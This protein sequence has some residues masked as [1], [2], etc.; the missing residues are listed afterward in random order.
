MI[1]SPLSELIQWLRA[2]GEPS[3]M[4]LL[5]LC[6]DAALSVSDLAHALRQSEPRVSRHLKILCESGLLERL[7]QGQWV[8][9]RLSPAPE[10]SSFVRGLLA[11]LDRRDPLLLR[12]AASAR[13]AAAADEGAR[14]AGGESRLGRALAGFVAAAAPAQRFD[15]LLLVGV[16]HPE[17]LEWAAGAS[18]HCT[19]LAPSRR[20][21]QSARA[22]AERRALACRVLHVR[23]GAENSST[24]LESVGP[25]FDALVLD[26]PPMSGERL[27]G[28]LESARALIGP[29]GVLWLFEPY[30]ALEGSRE[31]VVEHPLAR[32]RRLLAA[33][34]LRCEK[35]SPIEA[36][37]AHVLA[38]VARPVAAGPGLAAGA[39][40]AGR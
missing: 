16:T 31:R 15:S 12:D 8:H 22:F 11:Q 9:Y 7:R 1:Q 33:A 2:S 30:D 5:A 26:H 40:G 19:A 21:A 14:G 35:L 25:H 34:G 17:L 38:A 37:G 29:A 39:E 27:V 28:L 20:A 32:L 13:A 18:R 10:A 24:G 36:D 3:R 6:A 23:P 4:R